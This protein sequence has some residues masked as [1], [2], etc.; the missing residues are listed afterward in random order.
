MFLHWIV[1]ELPQPFEGTKETRSSRVVKPSQA[2][3]ALLSDRRV[4]GVVFRVKWNVCERSVSNAT[5]VFLSRRVSCG[6]KLWI[7]GLVS[8][9]FEEHTVTYLRHKLSQ[10]WRIFH[11]SQQNWLEC[12]D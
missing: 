1:I 5:S 4:D 2:F 9:S 6:G 12:W 7:Y 8:H 10:Q 3:S 11:K